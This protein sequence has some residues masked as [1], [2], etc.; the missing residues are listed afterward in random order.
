L[1][2]LHKYYPEKL[3]GRYVYLK[4][5]FGGA[6]F[7][8]SASY[9]LG[10]RQMF[11]NKVNYHT[12]WFAIVCIIGLLIW[13]Y[14]SKIIW[15]ITFD[16]GCKQVSIH[17]RTTFKVNNIII[18]RFSEVDFAYR[19]TPSRS[20]INDWTLFIFKKG[21]EVIRIAKRS[22]GFSEDTLKKIFEEGCKL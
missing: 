10:I 22:D 16:Y 9:F 18:C 17:Y 21:K 6:I 1:P 2:I 12:C 7:I 15:K 8:I 4:Q 5:A 14:T 11:R 20:S 19:R 3:S 13:L